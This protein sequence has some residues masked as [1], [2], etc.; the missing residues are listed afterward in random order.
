MFH[1]KCKDYYI[2]RFKLTQ[3]QKIENNIYWSFVEF[4]TGITR[5]EFIKKYFT[6]HTK[7]SDMHLMYVHNI[8]TDEHSGH[9][10]DSTTMYICKTNDAAKNKLINLLNENGVK[11]KILLKSKHLPLKAEI[12]SDYRED[13]TSKI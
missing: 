4:V 12:F 10:F 5:N 2:I 8:Y 13:L 6:K 7:A 3:K 11:F 1:I 9:F